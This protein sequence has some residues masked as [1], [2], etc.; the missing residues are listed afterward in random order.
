MGT[1]GFGEAGDG[2]EGPSRFA[3]ERA[4]RLGSGN[5]DAEFFGEPLADLL[6]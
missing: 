5:F 2:M 4:L 3:A 6:G 1:R